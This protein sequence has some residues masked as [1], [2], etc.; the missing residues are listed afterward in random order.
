MEYPVV[1]FFFQPYF[2]FFCRKVRHSGTASPLKHTAKKK[3]KEIKGI[4]S[5]MHGVDYKINELYS[6][7]QTAFLIS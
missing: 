2:F 7:T 1:L 5:A 4:P 3:N 6:V